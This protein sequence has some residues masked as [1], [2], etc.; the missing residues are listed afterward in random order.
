MLA[1][2]LSGVDTPPDNLSRWR[3]L[4]RFGCTIGGARIALGWSAPPRSHR[5]GWRSHVFAAEGW[6]HRERYETLSQCVA[7]RDAVIRDLTRQRQ[8]EPPRLGAS[9]RDPCV[10]QIV[11]GVHCRHVHGLRCP[12]TEQAH[13]E[14]LPRTGESGC[15]PGGWTSS[16]GWAPAQLIAGH[17]QAAE[18]LSSMNGPCLS[19]ASVR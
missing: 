11:G 3:L 7:S 18:G 15:H 16:G 12:V 9:G 8:V 13:C 17:L 1:A 14:P 2:R 4:M 19:T 10:A 5:A 6:V